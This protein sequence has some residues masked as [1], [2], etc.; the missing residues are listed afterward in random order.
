[1]TTRN[2]LRQRAVRHYKETTGKK[3]IDIREALKSVLSRSKL[4]GMAR[5]KRVVLA[6]L[7]ATRTLEGP[8]N[9]GRAWGTSGRDRGERAGGG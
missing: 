1:M 6:P 8:P 3:D 2:Q 4:L 9:L 7:N 5:F